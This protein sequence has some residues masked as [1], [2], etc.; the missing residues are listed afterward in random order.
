MK[1]SGKTIL[2]TG[3]GNGIGRELVLQLVNKGATVIAADMNLP[4]LEETRKLAGSCIIKQV[5]ITNRED[6]LALAAELEQ[7]NMP[8]DGL[9]NNAGIIQPFVKINQLEFKDIERVMN[10]NFYGTLN[11][12]KAFLPQLLKQKDAQIVNVSSMGG[13]L[14]VPGQAVYGAAKAAVKLFTEAL[15]SELLNTAVKVSVVFP[16]A[17]GTNIAGNSGVNIQAPK[18]KTAS[19]IKTL[20]AAKA[21]EIIINGMESNQFRIIVGSDSRFMD[22]LSR[23]NPGFATRFIQKKMR[24]LLPN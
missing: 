24:S 23:I 14:P 20:S 8:I 4:F 11:M 2:V 21:A 19:A 18:D 17:I 3:G 6:V 1:V 22:I 15:Y 13:F 9:I 16:G 10:V 7:N 5:D 12:V